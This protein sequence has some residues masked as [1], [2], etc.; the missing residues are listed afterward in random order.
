MSL[1]R[2]LPTPPVFISGYAYTVKRFS[3]AVVKK[4]SLEKK[5]NSLFKA[6]IKRKTLAS[7]EVLDTNF[8]LRKSEKIYTACLLRFS[9]FRPT[10]K[11]VNKVKLSIFQLKTFFKSVLAYGKHLHVLTLFRR[12]PHISGHF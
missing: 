10:R 6:L 8:C 9:K 7:R 1:S 2:T 11:W 12:R 3:I 4:L 5:Q